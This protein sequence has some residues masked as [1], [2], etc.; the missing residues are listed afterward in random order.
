MIVRAYLS[1]GSLGDGFRSN[2]IEYSQL[3]ECVTH[4]DFCR[5]GSFFKLIS[6]EELEIYKQ[7]VLDKEL[8]NIEI[9]EREMLKKLKE[10]Y[11]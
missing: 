11:E 4:S 9:R 2:P 1:T 6:K 10:K 7:E 3:S 5:S 8:K